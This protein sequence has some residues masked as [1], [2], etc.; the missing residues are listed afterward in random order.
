MPDG[1]LFLLNPGRT[2]RAYLLGLRNAAARLGIP[3]VAIELAPVWEYFKQGGDRLQFASYV[4]DLVRANSIATAIG[5]GFNGVEFGQS[6]AAPPLLADLGLVHLMLWTDHP[7]WCLN[8]AP[9]EEPLRTRLNHPLHVHLLK[10]ESAAA[11]ASR[12]LGWR[13]IHSMHMAEDTVTVHPDPIEPVY[14]V[15]SVLSDAA[16]L[17]EALLPFLAESDPV[18]ATLDELMRPAALAAFN[19]VV[20]QESP[21]QSPERFTPLAQEWLDAKQAH[22]THSLFRLSAKLRQQENLRWLEAAPTRW[23]RAISALRRMTAWRR[24]FW[25]AWLARRA[26]VCVFGSDARSLGVT[27]PPGADAWVPYDRL[28]STF[29]QGRLAININASH[30]EEGLTHKP[31]QIAA[32]GVACLHHSSEGLESVLDPHKEVAVFSNGRELLAHVHELLDNPHRRFD[33]A[34]AAQARA[35]TE[36]DWANRWSYLLP[37]AAQVRTSS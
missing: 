5:Y 8:A 29:A 7:E 26:N 36:H 37:L 21:A 2:S 27:Q 3:T 12:V 13:N 15:V 11:E 14:D 32:A 9:L 17:P 25:L 30:D 23:Y 28:A 34:Q 4:R 24:S 35:R 20:R 6:P 31:F 1:V 33:M 22:P 18:P 16:P 10:S 19:K